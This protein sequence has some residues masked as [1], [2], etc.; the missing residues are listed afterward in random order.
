MILPCSSI[1]K[2]CVD[3]S[4][5]RTPLCCLTG[6]SRI[7]YTSW[8]SHLD[9]KNPA[10]TDRQISVFR[11]LK[12]H[13]WAR[14]WPLVLSGS[15]KRRR[16]AE[17]VFSWQHRQ[18]KL[19]VYHTITNATR[20]LRS[21]YVFAHYVIAMINNWEVPLASEVY[22]RSL[23]LLSFPSNPLINAHLLDR[24]PCIPTEA[25]NPGSLQHEDQ[26]GR[27]I[28]RFYCTYATSFQVAATEIGQGQFVWNEHGLEDIDKYE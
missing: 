2:P 19:E 5:H 6:C 23:S 9:E 22:L 3:V 14:P 26:F 16:W 15:W 18:V 11:L 27:H 4:L 17:Y 28:I 8:I 25:S 13:F 21:L 20:Q 10:H 1:T 24:S 7:Y 12:G